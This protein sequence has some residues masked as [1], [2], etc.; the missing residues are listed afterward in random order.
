MDWADLVAILSERYGDDEEYLKL[1]LASCKDARDLG[2]DFAPLDPDSL[3]EDWIDMTDGEECKLSEVFQS[4][5]EALW[6]AGRQALPG[7]RDE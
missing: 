2:L 3:T 6:H 1:A 5:V 4:V 7:W